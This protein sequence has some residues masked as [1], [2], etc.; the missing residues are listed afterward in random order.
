L[1]HTCRQSLTT[2]LP[3]SRDTGAVRPF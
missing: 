1:A 3:I 2:P